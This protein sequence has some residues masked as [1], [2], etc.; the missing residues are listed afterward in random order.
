[1]WYARSGKF[2]RNKGTNPFRKP[3]LARKAKPREVLVENLVLEVH[4]RGLVGRTDFKPPKVIT[5]NW[6]MH[7]T[8]DRRVG[9]KGKA[10]YFET[11]I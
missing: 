10:R 6:I 8:F 11:V 2:A 3:E 4:T 7:N 1:V 9:K 5:E